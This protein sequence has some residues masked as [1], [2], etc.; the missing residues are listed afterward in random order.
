[1]IDSLSRWLVRTRAVQRGLELL[2]RAPTNSVLILPTTRGALELA[3]RLAAIRPCR[4]T[5]GP[6]SSEGRWRLAR[7]L[8]TPA[9]IASTFAAD[10][11]LPCMVISFPDQLLGA[12]PAFCPVPFLGTTYWFSAIEALLVMRHRPA[13]YALRTCSARGDFFIHAIHYEDLLDLSGRARSLQALMGRLLAALEEELTHPSSDWLAAQYF[14]LKS[15]SGMR[16]RQREDLK[17]IECLL[18][19]HACS[20]SCDTLRT[21]TAIA[22]VV[23]RQKSL[24]E[25]V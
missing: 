7:H 21:S 11:Y 2:M 12:G 13:V 1:M 6:V 15:Q 19:L 3:R 25:S 22:A 8:C 5:A 24:Y 4:I 23:A 17:E 18:R 20:V 16:F 10:S 14:K 9:D